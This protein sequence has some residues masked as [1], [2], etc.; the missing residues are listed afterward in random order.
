MLGHGKILEEFKLLAA[1]GKLKQGYL[2]FGPEGVGKKLLVLELAAHLEHHSEESGRP[3]S[4]AKIISP[5]NGTIGVDE[6]REARGF[7]S[8]RPFASPYRTLI[9]DGG[10]SLTDEAANALLKITEE[11][12]PSALIFLVAVDPGAIRETL[13]SRFEKMYLGPLSTKEM[14]AWLKKEKKLP[15][16]RAEKVAKAS[17]GRPGLAHRILEDEQFQKLQK[18]AAAFLNQKST[19]LKPFIKKMLEDEEFSLAAFLDMIILLVSWQEKKNLALWHKVLELRSI[20]DS[21]SLSP[22]I[23]LEYLWKHTLKS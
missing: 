16:E 19:T 18:D 12:P 17:F 23:Q 2:L 10:E 6:A 13:A 11:P 4:D 1:A 22:R 9:V 14:Q 7:L 5:K 20:E 15:A 8:G 21:F 3:L